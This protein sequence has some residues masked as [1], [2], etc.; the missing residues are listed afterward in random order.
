MNLF[1]QLPRLTNGVAEVH[2]TRLGLQL[3]QASHHSARIIQTLQRICKQT[4]KFLECSHITY[5]DATL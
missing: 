4:V 5:T 2:E 3:R 1:S